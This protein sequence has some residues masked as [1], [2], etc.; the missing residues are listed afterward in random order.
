MRDTDKLIED[1]A[2]GAK[3]V[4]PLAS[5][6][7]RASVL[8]AGLLAAMA[9]LAAFGGHVTETFAHLT[10]MPFTLELGGALFAGIGAIA[11]AIALSIPGRSQVWAYLPLPGLAL[12]LAGGGLECYR[13]VSDLGYTPASLFD[14][15]DC[16]FFIVGAGLPTAAASY[17]F[18]RRHL[19]IDSVRVTALA[20]LGSALLAAALLQFIHAHGT[21]PV[22]FA[23]H[24]VAVILL[25]LFAT[26]LARFNS[27]P[28]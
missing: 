18:L 22:D 24:I 19:S 10:H 28:G 6:L 2:A 14:S 20:T 27:R 25:M 26:T 11:A 8:L 3:P 17:I 4:K 7:T 12:W 5:P 13:Q 16:F 23:T 9:T 15:T 1:L 21:N